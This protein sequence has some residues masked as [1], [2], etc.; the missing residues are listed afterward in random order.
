[1]TSH[2]RRKGKTSENP[3]PE[4]VPDEYESALKILFHGYCLSK[5]IPRG[6]ITCIAIYKRK[7]TIT[8]TKDIEIESIEVVERTTNI[9]E[10]RLLIKCPTLIHTAVLEIPF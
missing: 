10:G 8:Y 4:Q 1:M 7:K 3:R 6:D 2:D 5:N 9:S